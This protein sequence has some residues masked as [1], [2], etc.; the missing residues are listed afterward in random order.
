MTIPARLGMFF[1]HLKVF[2]CV[3]QFQLENSPRPKKTATQQS[4]TH[5]QSGKQCSLDLAQRRSARD[6]KPPERS[7][8][9]IVLQEGE[10]QQHNVCRFYDSQLKLADASFLTHPQK[11]TT[12]TT[13]TKLIELKLV[14]LE[15]ISMELRLWFASLSFTSEKK[16]CWKWGKRERKKNCYGKLP[17]WSKLKYIVYRGEAAAARVLSLWICWF[18]VVCLTRNNKALTVRNY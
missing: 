18:A 17:K 1:F 13:M 3:I 5:K 11:S 10:Q 8:S 7:T 12:A 2:F 4:S 6:I 9:R 15:P 16:C 14:T